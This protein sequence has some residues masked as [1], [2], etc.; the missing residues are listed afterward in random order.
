[1]LDRGEKEKEEV[2]IKKVAR[3]PRDIYSFPL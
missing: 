2:R 3:K 1:M